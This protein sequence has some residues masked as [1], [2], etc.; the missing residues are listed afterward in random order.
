MEPGSEPAPGHDLKVVTIGG[1]LVTRDD[2]VKALDALNGRPGTDTWILPRLIDIESPLA[3]TAYRRLADQY[4]DEHPEDNLPKAEPGTRPARRRVA[5]I[6][7][8][9]H[10]LHELDQESGSLTSAVEHDE[11]DEDDEA[12]EPLP[13]DDVDARLRVQAEIFRRQGQEGFRQELMK[14]YSGRCAVTDCDVKWALEAAH[15][16]RYLGPASNDARNG[17]LLRA[18]IHS[19]FDLDLLGINPDTRKIV[20]SW[21]LTGKHYKPLSG[22][23][24]ADP[25]EEKQR[26]IKARLAERWQRFQ[27]KQQTI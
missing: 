24:L 10:E 14:A 16:R 17:L 8:L 5:F 26:P 11:D 13:S 12:L 1:V 18:D 2:I 4:Q 3:R 19:L 9:E 25:K 15:I 20:L 7:L 27:E 6:H 23:L 21:R 22:H